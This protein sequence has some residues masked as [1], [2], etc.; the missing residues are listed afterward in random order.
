MVYIDKD[1]L[2]TLFKWYMQEVGDNL[3]SV[4]VVDHDGLVVEILTRDSDKL[5]E[6]KFVGAF[7]SLVELVLKKLTKDFDLGT[8]GAG[9]FDTDKYRFIF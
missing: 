7:S 5:D 8:F 4:L 1:K 3:V 9:T 2:I 6:K